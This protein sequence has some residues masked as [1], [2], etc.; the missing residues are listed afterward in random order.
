M[1]T[2]TPEILT[3]GFLGFLLMD[4]MVPFNPLTPFRSGDDTDRPR[5]T[6]TKSPTLNF[7]FHAAKPN[8]LPMEKCF[9]FGRIVP[10]CWER[11][12][13]KKSTQRHLQK[14]TR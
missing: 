8:L 3:V 10:L 9:R 1:R 12:E 6:T 7:H 14:A 5:V 4:S 11:R 2:V 13:R